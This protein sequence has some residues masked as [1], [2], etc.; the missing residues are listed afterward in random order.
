M[1]LPQFIRHRWKLLLSALLL[2]VYGFSG[3]CYASELPDPPTRDE[4]ALLAHGPLP[5]RVVVIAWD[6]AEAARRHQNGTAYAQATL[7]WL[8]SSGA[9]ESVRLGNANDTATDLLASPTGAYCN[10]AVVPMFT[11]ISLG[12][13]PT[14]FTDRTC[15]GAVFH[16]LQPTGARSDSVVIRSELANRVIMGWLA[17]VVGALP[18]WT[19][20][21]VGT[22]RRARQ[23]AG[24]AIL[25]YRSHLMGLV[26]SAR[27]AP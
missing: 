9:F 25:A 13:I 22:N 19:H 11:I 21:D 27:T 23:R 14:I 1:T 4:L 3:G 2:V 7:Q 20:G 18:G 10:S 15:E 24:V 12:V 6:P 8:E 26:E 5:Y 16:A 17:V